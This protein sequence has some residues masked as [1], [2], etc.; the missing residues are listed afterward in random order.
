MT[1]MV[2]LLDVSDTFLLEGRGR[3]LI[4]YFHPGTDESL[5]SGDRIQLRSQ[6]GESWETTVKG[7]ELVNVR[8]RPVDGR[9]PIGVLISADLPAAAGQNGVE[10]WKFD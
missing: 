1:R 9:Y 6:T 7:I 5:T 3:V 8:P 4:C 10:I 2:H